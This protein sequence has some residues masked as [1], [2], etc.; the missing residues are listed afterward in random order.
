MDLML[1]YWNLLKHCFFVISAS[2]P[3]SRLWIPDQ[4]RDDTVIYEKI[5]NAPG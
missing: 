2:E 4:V 1:F 3:E 5:G